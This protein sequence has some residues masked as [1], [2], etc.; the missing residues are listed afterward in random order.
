MSSEDSLSPESDGKMPSSSLSSCSNM[1]S[2][3]SLS[4]EPDHSS[5]SVTIILKSLE[6]SWFSQ[7]SENET[8]QQL[9]N[10]ENK[11]P[12]I[13]GYRQSK[14]HIARQPSARR[15]IRRENKC[16][17]ALSLP[18]IS[19]Y[20]MRSIWGKLK[21][22]SDDMHERDCSLSFLSEVWEKRENIIHK[23]KIEEMLELRNI[24]YIST[25]RPG[26]KRG[27]GAAIAFDPTKVSVSKLDITIPTPLEIV[28]ALYRPLVPTGHIKKII[29]CSFYSP[30][31]SK[32]NRQLIDHI[33]LTYN[34][35]KIKH[36]DAYI[37]MSGDKNNLDEINI[38][39]LNPDFCQI[40]SRNTR[41][42][43]ILTVLITD[44]HRFYHVPIIIPPVPV[45]VPGEGVP[46]DHQGVLAV[47]FTS[48]HSHRTSQARKVKVR[49]LPETL[50]SKFGSI[51]VGE[52]WSFIE[53]QLTPTL[54]VEKFE[55]YSSQVINDT[56]PEKVVTISDYDKPYMTEELKLIRRRR[57][58]IY[59]KYGK[60][61]EYV[62]LKE[63]FDKKLKL[64]A[65][66][67][68]QKV[69]IEVNEGKRNNLY[70]ALR[71][72]DPAY[73]NKKHT[74]FTL[75]SHVEQNFSSAES[76]EALAEY[77]SLISQKFEPISVEKFPP[78]LKQKLVLGKSDLSKPVLEEW[79][80]YQKLR[81]SKKPNSQ[82]PGDLPVKLIKEF[83]PELSKPITKIFNKITQTAHYPRQWVVE[84][85]LAIPKVNPP[86]SENEIRN[87]ASTAYFSKQYESFIGDWLLPFIEPFLDPG[88]CGG[89][90]GSSITHYLVK[91]LHF[92]H[93]HVDSKQPHAV[94]LA[95]IDLEKA[96]NR[97]SHQQ[98]IEDLFDMHVPGWLLLIIIS[99][100]TERSMFMRYKGS[101]SSRK[102]LPGSSPQGAFLGI[103]LFI[104]IFNGALLRPAIPR[105]SS[106]Y[107]KY[108][109]DLSM[110]AAFN[111]MRCLAPA[112]AERAMPLTYNQ[113][114]GHILSPE[115]NTLQEDLLSLENFAS[116]KQ[117]K[118]K[119][120][121]TQVMKFNFSKNY[122]FP[123]ELNLDG[124]EDSLKVINETKLLGVMVTDDLK[125]NSNTK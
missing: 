35:L 89:L 50:I 74:S 115:Y 77:F 31:N 84:Y 116:S 70:S 81:K 25:P 19:S 43:K 124:F 71:K 117:S 88:Q 75:P 96:F 87:I 46:S 63:L 111:L 65:E 21:C 2:D 28:W 67:Y 29:L 92:V 91:L 33:S 66:K 107:L 103:L 69:I 56:F 59:R 3:E 49:P 114:T 6:K 97:V 98:V 79:Q 30:P 100:L 72:L 54:M 61:A 53:P 104:I 55:A 27:G 9:P 108:I 37:I 121:K 102:S 4:P 1:S 11:I 40:V 39:A 8:S 52:N 5:T 16:V 34:Q 15:T 41:K 68:R 73:E 101:M 105:L 24:S 42:S 113:R 51:L 118:I 90:K 125:W 93:K 13:Y 110:L 99:Y 18:I 38:L 95:L 14:P 86:L 60:C 119:E 123:P 64:Q 120:S 106:M 44:L 112:P 22:F 45:D 80:V 32:K 78:C 47:P 109:D 10:S 85:Q 7:S 94:L 20:N 17:E 58:R 62:R 12:V 83:L 122:D 26:N 48:L 23:K 36:P 57:Q 82:V 76:A